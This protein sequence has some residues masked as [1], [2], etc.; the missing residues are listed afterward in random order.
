MTRWKAAAIHLSISIAIGLLS[1]ALIFG[2]WYPPPYSRATG[3]PELVMLLLGVDLVLGPLLT[4]AVFKAGKKG[5]KFDLSVIAL[6][7]AGA[8]LYGLSVVARARPAFIV[9]RIDRFVLVSANDL[10]PK[11]LAEGKP[12]F[13]S[14]PWTGPR[15]VGVELPPAGKERDDLLFSGI[16]GKDVEKYPK[17]YV[18]Y[19]TAV[20][21]LLSHAKMIDELRREHPTAAS[22]IDAWLSTHGRDPTTLLAVPII[23]PRGDL[24]ML[25]DRQTGKPFDALPVD[26]W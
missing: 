21:Q 3:A 18:D 9:G 13:R 24:T 5:L 26:I 20:P 7:Q 16:A 25:I 19:A 2:L 11:D 10:D 4:L 23:A 22:K 6:L 12:G 17:Y 14:P 15:L 1:A 8:L